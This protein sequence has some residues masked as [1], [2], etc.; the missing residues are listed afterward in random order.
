MLVLQKRHFNT[1]LKKR[2][3]VN[4]SCSM[5]SGYFLLW[6]IACFAACTE[7]PNLTKT[8]VTGFPTPVYD[9]MVA[10][11]S[12]TVL[13]LLPP[14][15]VVYVQPDSLS[16]SNQDFVKIYWNDTSGYVPANWLLDG[17]TIGVI[18]ASPEH[19]VV[20][21]DDP[22]EKTPS[23][24][25][26]TE[27][28][29]VS[30]KKYSDDITQVV[31]ANEKDSSHPWFGYIMQP[32]F[33]DSLSVAFFNAYADANQKK[34]EGNNTALDALMNDT[35]FNA[36][37]LRQ[38]VFASNSSG[39]GGGSGHHTEMEWTDANGNKLTG[40]AIPGQFVLHY[41]WDDDSESD[42]N[43][44]GDNL[45][46]GTPEC[47][48]EGGKSAKAYKMIFTAKDHIDVTFTC[49]IPM[50]TDS[51]GPMTLT[52][53]AVEPNTPYEFLITHRVYGVVCDETTFT[54]T[55]SLGQKG[56]GMVHASCGD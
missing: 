4:Y 40:D 25:T 7:K 24:A 9:G 5:K 11:T 44:L 29:L 56:Q 15:T 36:V 17:G 38:S 39:S 32:V 10:A 8:A 52:Y 43:H 33:S 23:G 27:M 31:Y 12:G 21:S 46:Q 45:E 34:R 22:G 14:Q 55:T 16:I 37:A 26:F 13:K 6:I 42:G 19:P 47:E 30:F 41:I 50:I 20:I 54:V 35:R 1:R 51:E 2:N 3:I 18:D 53:Q 28:Q 48:P 49:L